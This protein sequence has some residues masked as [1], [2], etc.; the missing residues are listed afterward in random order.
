MV[1]VNFMRGFE[2]FLIVFFLLLT[3]S[4]FSQCDT[5]DFYAFYYVPNY[6]EDSN[7]WER[8]KLSFINNSPSANWQIAIE[9]GERGFVPGS[10][11]GVTSALSFDALNERK[12]VLIYE[13]LD[14]DKVYDLY[15]C[16]KLVGTFQD[17]HPLIDVDF[18][19]NIQKNRLYFVPFRSLTTDQTIVYPDFQ[20]NYFNI[21]ALPEYQL[22]GVM[23]AQFLTSSSYETHELLM[24]SKKLSIEVDFDFLPGLNHGFLSMMPIKRNSYG[25]VSLVHSQYQYIQYG[26]D[27]IDEWQSVDM[28]IQLPSNESIGGWFDFRF[29]DNSVH[30]WVDSTSGIKNIEIVAKGDRREFCYGGSTS[31]YGNTVFKEGIYT[32]TLTNSL[33]VDSVVYSTLTFHPPLFV[34]IITSEHYQATGNWNS[35]SWFN[36]EN[37]I[38]I[39]EGKD[40][41]PE[42]NGVYYVEVSDNNCTEISDCITI[43]KN[44]GLNELVENSFKLYPN[45][46]KEF[47]H[48]DI[49]NSDIN[50]IE[51][52]DLSGKIVLVKE[53]NINSTISLDLSGLSEGVYIVKL[54]SGVGKVISSKLI[55]H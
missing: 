34:D 17:A 40:F 43:D 6:S 29:V 47:V 49:A 16:D 21:H 14:H 9:Y 27:E 54:H 8:V 2:K 26:V 44:I 32:D 1:K 24:F 46:A 15:V 52:I 28:D 12:D 50:R 33:G 25:P 22:N 19:L 36:C 7:Q 39:S 20:P 4:A 18:N 48:I 53:K 30:G 55:V 37:D 31:I 38:L 41:F 51:L 23:N 45:P 42:F 3:T 11:E 13:D 10:G 5:K 35:Y